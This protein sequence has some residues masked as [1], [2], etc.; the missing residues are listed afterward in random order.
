MGFFDLKATCIYCEKEVG[1]NRF[2]TADGWLCPGCYKLSGYSLSTN[3]RTKTITDIKNDILENERQREKLALFHPSKKIGTFIEFDEEKR[4]WLIPD[5]FMGKKKNPRIYSYDDIVEYELLEDGD[6]ITKGGLGR[7][8]VGGA[9]F[10]GTGAIVGGVTGGKRSKKVINSLKIKITID[11][12]ESPV[13]YIHLITSKTKANSFV[14]KTNFALAQ[15]ILSTFALIQKQREKDDIHGSSTNKGNTTPSPA[16]EIL[17]YKEL[18]D[19]GIITQEEFKA[20]KK[21]LLGL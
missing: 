4:Q 21:Q 1:L 7:A 16:D 20:K 12:F 19:Q 18:M 3:T 13:V 17:K 11:D 10:G 14:Y 15:E 9:V 5:G 2:K 8:L 6:T